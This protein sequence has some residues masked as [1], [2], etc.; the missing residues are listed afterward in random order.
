MRKLSTIALVSCLTLGATAAMAAQTTPS[1]SM[2][3]PATSGTMAKTTK[4][5]AKTTTTTTTK[6]KAG[7]ASGALTAM[8]ATARTI[9]VKD[10]YT[11]TDTTKLTAK[12]KAITMA[13]LHVG[14]TVSVTYTKNGA[15]WDATRVVVTKAAKM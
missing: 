7:H 4:A 14:D 2:D 5:A 10:T 13:D 12:G 11:V 15:N 8:D 9:T 6:T 1:T 3:K